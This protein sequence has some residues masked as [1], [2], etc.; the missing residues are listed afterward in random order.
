MTS[1]I[2]TKD[3]L[4]ADVKLSWSKSSD[5]DGRVVRYLIFDE[6]DME[7]VKLTET[8]ATDYTLRGIE[9]KGSHRL[10]L[11]AVDDDGAQS[12]KTMIIVGRYTGIQIDAAGLFL[13]PFGTGSRFFG[14]GA[15]AMA[16]ISLGK[17]LIPRFR[18]GIEAGYLIFS[19]RGQVGRE[20]RSVP[21]LGSNVSARVG[22]FVRAGYFGIFEKDGPINFATASAGMELRF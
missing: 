12:P 16:S 20:M 9:L 6:S 7:P 5:P 3:K 13:Y 10:S 18:P 17:P 14:W 2:V 1:S 19:G 4:H 8:D 22:L 21:I 11:V 15:G